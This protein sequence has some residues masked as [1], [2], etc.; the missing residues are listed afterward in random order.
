MNVYDTVNLGEG[1][2]IEFGSSTWDPKSTSVRNRYL[3]SSGGFSP[4]SS[5]EIPL[6]DFEPIGV[7]IANRDLLNPGTCAR[8]IQALAN[9]VARRS[10]RRCELTC[11]SA[12][13]SSWVRAL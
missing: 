6:E 13:Q 9:S 3:T 10:T 8:I 2:L 11:P 4:H 7:E 1:H 5:S 12:F